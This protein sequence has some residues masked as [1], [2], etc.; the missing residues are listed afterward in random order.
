MRRPTFQ[1]VFMRP[2]P[3][4]YALPTREGMKKND[5]ETAI[6]IRED[7][8]FVLRHDDEVGARNVAPTTLKARLP[9]NMT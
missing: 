5:A 9:Q 6:R 1:D 3:S 2:E 4:V 7:E 8:K